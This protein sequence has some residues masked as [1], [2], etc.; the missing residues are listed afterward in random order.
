M[1]IEMVFGIYLLCVVGIGG[2]EFEFFKGMKVCYRY[3]KLGY[4]ESR[5]VY[6]GIFLIKWIDERI[7]K[8]C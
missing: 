5:G 7:W 8:M 3:E 6:C 4:V 2:N 1:F